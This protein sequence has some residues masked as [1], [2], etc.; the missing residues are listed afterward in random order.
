MG[1]DYLGQSGLRTRTDFS[2]QIYQNRCTTATMSGSTNIGDNLRANWYSADTYN[3]TVSAT[4]GSTVVFALNQQPNLNTWASSVQINP[5]QIPTADN[6]DLQIN[7]TT[8]EVT[9]HSSSLRYKYDVEVLPFSSYSKLLQLEPKKFKWTHNG[10]ESIGLIAEEV[11][12]LGLK[13]FVHYDSEG[14]PDGVKYKLLAVGLMGV[15]KNGLLDG[16]I[17]SDESDKKSIKIINDNY[18]TNKEDYLIVKG[19]NSE[20]TLIGEEGYKVYIKSMVECLVKTSVGLI[21]D[22]W[23]SLQ[24]G[25]ESCIELIFTEGSWYILSS[26]G[27]KNS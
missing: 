20:I 10:Q 1:Y 13:D 26:D 23:G 18:T 27:I 4:T 19:E 21:D 8:G 6:L 17:N 14:K 24:L 7:T 3:F 5:N 25:S 11:D 22:N 2:R 16:L 9:K 15:L 12:S